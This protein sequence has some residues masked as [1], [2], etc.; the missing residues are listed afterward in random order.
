M[1]N[2]L[3]ISTL[4]VR[5]PIAISKPGHKR[6]RNKVKNKR[7]TVSVKSMN[8]ALDNCNTPMTI[9]STLHSIF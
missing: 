8:L 5:S 9:E 6:L 1:M 7:A 4:D 2:K 3:H